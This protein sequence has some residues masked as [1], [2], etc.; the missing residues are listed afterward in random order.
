VKV[1]SLKKKVEKIIEVREGMDCFGPGR[2]E[3]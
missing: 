3:A 1:L 2:M